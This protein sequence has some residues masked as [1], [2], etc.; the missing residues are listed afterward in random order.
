MAAAAEAATY[1]ERQCL[2]RVTTLGP[3]RS[4]LMICG[5]HAL[6]HHFQFLLL[7]FVY[8]LKLGGGEPRAWSAEPGPRKEIRGRF[9]TEGPSKSFVYKPLGR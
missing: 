4:L 7:K 3:Q 6:K 2:K 8:Q 5:K 1:C 9:H